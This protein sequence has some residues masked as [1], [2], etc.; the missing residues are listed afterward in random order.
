MSCDIEEFRKIIFKGRKYN[1][2]KFALAK[3]LLDYSKECIVIEDKKI[4]YLV[5]ANAFLEYYWEQVCKKDIKQVSDK[6]NIPF[7]VKIIKDYCNRKYIDKSGI[8]KEI[9]KECFKDVIPRF[10]YN[11]GIFY[12]HYHELH[13]GNYK[14]PPDD[15]RYIYLFKESIA[16]FRDNYELLNGEVIEEWERFLEKFND[17]FDFKLF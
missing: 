5:I 7:V 2:Y 13:R 8:I 12:Q 17:G 16:F 9:A 3:F 1:S 11:N 10:Q 15:K 6:Q 4:D 14:M